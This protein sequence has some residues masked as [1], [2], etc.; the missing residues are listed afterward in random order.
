MHNP[1]E[2]NI[3]FLGGAKRVSVARHFIHTAKEMGLT[4]RIFSYELDE[5]V[6]IAAVGTV[7]K[8]LRWSDPELM[9]DL[10]RVVEEHGIDIVLPFVD[11]AI[12]VAR[13]LKDLCPE[14]FIPVSEPSVCITMFDKMLSARWFAAHG[15]SQPKFYDARTEVRYPVILKPRRGS[16][17]KGLIICHDDSEWPQLNIF[18]DYLV[19][20]YIADS[21]EYSVDCYVNRHGE[22]VSIVPRL[23]LEMAG[24][25]AVKSLTVRDEAII[26]QS[27]HILRSGEFLG[28]VTIQFIKDNAS[29]A[30]YVMEINPRLGGGVVTSICAG[31]GIIAMILEEYLGREVAPHTLWRENTLMVR[32]LQEVIFYADCD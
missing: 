10:T 3:L 11:P 22:P 30:V 7:I 16:A 9:A 29:G 23:R 6:A 32:Y 19:Q 13:R 21:T 28:P 20:D 18:D 15:V 1:S 24:G 14:V 4:A 2:V 31:S 26:S 12:L 25:E 8:G 27:D 5:R 17:S